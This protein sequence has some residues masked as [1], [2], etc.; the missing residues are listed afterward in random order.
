[1]IKG[2]EFHYSTVLEWKGDDRD[3]AFRM[4]KGRGIH[5]QR[6]GICYKNVFATYTHIHALGIKEW[7]ETLVKL[8]TDFA[9]SK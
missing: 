5:H 6:D 1:V 9:S 7:A 4:S 8:A 2:H 3:M